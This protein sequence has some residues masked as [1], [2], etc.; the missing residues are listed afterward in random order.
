[1]T[2]LTVEHAHEPIYRVI[3]QDWVDPLDASFSQRAIDNR[4]NTAEFPALYCCCS[5][6]VARAVTLD[7]FRMSGVELDDLQ[8]AYR[9]QLV[10]ISWTGRVVDVASPEGIEASQLPPEYPQLVA[11]WQTRRMAA[12]W[13]RSGNEGV[14]S[15]SASLERLRFSAWTGSHARWGEIA[16]FA[17][18]W[19]TGPMLLSR[20]TDMAWFSIPRAG[21]NK[22]QT[23]GNVVG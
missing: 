10:E 16:L 14:L 19:N 12:V 6:A 18:N 5:E 20:R 1:M 22:T 21:A 13:H 23:I 11:K 9:P 2:P 7:I 8:L 15:R 3:R 4:W 17:R